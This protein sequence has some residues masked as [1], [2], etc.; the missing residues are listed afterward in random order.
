M[1]PDDPCA[2]E[3][4]M[5]GT[6]AHLMQQIRDFHANHDESSQELH[7]NH[8]VVCLG[9][10]CGSQEVAIIKDLMEHGILIEACIF[11]DPFVRGA[12]MQRAYSIE[13]VD[14]INVVDSYPR[15]LEILRRVESTHPPNKQQQRRLVVF[16]LNA[17]FRF[18]KPRDLYDFHEFLCFCARH[19]Q[20][21]SQ[22]QSQFQSSSLQVLPNL[23]NY[24]YVIHRAQ[25]MDMSPCAPGSR[26]YVFC[27]GWW[28]M[29][30]DYMT[31]PA[32]Q[33]VLLKY[34]SAFD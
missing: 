15:V 12:L 5:P 32:G 17:G 19:S 30:C 6:L 13:G 8:I 27:K 2:P 28:E 14:D 4:D 7:V 23:L 34:D 10:G 9:C 21:Q 20:F 26:T 3:L 24:L 25:A 22:S 16:G 33:H 11:M 31:C 29:A 1:M 18:N